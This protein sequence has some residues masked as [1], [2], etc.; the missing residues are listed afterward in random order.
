MNN[1]DNPTIWNAVLYLP[2]LEAA[3]TTPFEDIAILIPST[4]MSLPTNI[5]AIQI[6]ILDQA[7]NIITTELTSSLSASGSKNLP[8]VV[9]SLFFLAK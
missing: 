9:T 7:A 5:I 3:I 2:H 4:K 8:N 6:G 1:I